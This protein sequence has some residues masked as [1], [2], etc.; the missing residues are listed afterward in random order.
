MDDGCQVMAIPHMTLWVRWA[1]KVI[2]NYAQQEHDMKW[3][4]YIKFDD[5]KQ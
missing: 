3:Y 4:I 1:K 5:Y 2:L